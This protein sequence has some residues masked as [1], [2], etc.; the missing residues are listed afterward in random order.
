MKKVFIVA[1]A[2]CLSISLYASPTD[3]SEKVLKIFKQSF[4]SAKD[5][6]WT[7]SASNYSVSFLLS[8][9][10]S[11]VVYDKEGNIVSSIRYYSP[12]YLPMNVYRSLLKKYE[13]KKL[14]G[15]TEVAVEENIVYYVKMYDEKYWYT[16]KTDNSGGLQITEKLKRADLGQF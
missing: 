9:I 8:G 11:K 7:E 2:A 12:Q 1:V 13:N 16:V 4:S 3:V 6:K 10:Q 5:V 14:F 15:V